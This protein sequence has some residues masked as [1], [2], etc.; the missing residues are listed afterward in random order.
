MTVRDH[1]AV[2]A[3]VEQ[4]FASYATAIDDAR[5]DFLD[6]MFEDDA[7]FELILPDAS[8]TV[9]IQGATA[10]RDFL[11]S[12][13]TPGQT[14]H[15]LTNLSLTQGEADR[16]VARLYLTF[17][18]TDGGFAVKTTGVYKADLAKADDLWKFHSLSLALDASIA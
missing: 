9:A 17:C 14:R 8:E 2:R 16:A 6:A 12:A 11:G 10:I 4:L 18:A 1:L 3:D 7:N 5:F 13:R 15:V